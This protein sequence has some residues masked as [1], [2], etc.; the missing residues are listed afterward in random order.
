MA[1]PQSDSG[2]ST[3]RISGEIGGVLFSG[4]FPADDETSYISLPLLADLGIDI[5]EITPRGK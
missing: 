4:S 1:R 2:R 5:E 3:R